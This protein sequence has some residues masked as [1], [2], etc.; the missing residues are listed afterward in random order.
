MIERYTGPE[1]AKIW[2][3]DNKFG[4]WLKIEVLACEKM[5]ELGIIPKKDLALIKKKAGFSAKRIDEIEKT[6]NHDVIAFLTSV[7][8][9]VGPASRHIHYGM[10][11][12]DVLDTSLSV[13]MREAADLL[14]GKLGVLINETKKKSLKYKFTPMIGR[15]HGVHAEPVTFG[16]KMG[17]MFTELK[18]VCERLKASRE[19]VSVVKISGAVGTHAHLPASVE[20]Y[21]AKKLGMKP[22][23]I[24]TQIIQRDR[25][26]DF[27]NSIAL[28]GAVLE[29]WALELRNLQRTEIY[30]VEE[31]FAKGQ[32]GSSAMPHK[33]NPI[34]CERICGL[35]RVL[36]SNAMAGLENVALWHERDITHSSV[37]RIIIP[38]STIL[39]DYML[40]LMIKIIK[41]LN[42][43]PVNMMN[44][45]FRTKGLVFSQRVMLELTR[46]GI[47]REKA[48][49]I[50]QRNA[51][52]VWKTG[53]DFKELLMRD[54]ELK[55]LMKPG[56]IERCFDLKYYFRDV[57]RMFKAAG[58]TAK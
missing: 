31:Y 52:E 38:D 8:E 11:S 58:L 18:R 23:A 24:S 2:S 44:N 25:H 54:E 35:A 50:V 55:T 6:V 27:L 26:A 29:K 30:E 40:S 3:Q 10:T 20:S 7:A 42:V 39:L 4:T 14:L 19:I 16:L 1:M 43:Y 12:S 57:N 37:E 17:L 51:M 13:L 47:S 28:A 49:K 5:A 22:A 21:V 53:R 56:E 46:K 45:I 33:R 9:H 15:S 36:R 34:T 48:Y 41:N 32:K